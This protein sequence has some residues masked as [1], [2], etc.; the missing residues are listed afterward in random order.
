[1]PGTARSGVCPPAE[2]DENALDIVSCSWRSEPDAT[3]RSARALAVFRPEG[4]RRRRL[5]LVFSREP[6]GFAPRPAEIPGQTR[7]ALSLAL[8]TEDSSADEFDKSG[9][10][11][12]IPVEI[13]N[14]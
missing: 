4:G 11:S 10:K 7:P 8:S 13:D 3:L 1:M 6:T 14:C 2:R 12:E 9:L 5:D